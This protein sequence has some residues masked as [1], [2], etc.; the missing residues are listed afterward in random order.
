MAASNIFGRG[1]NN[2]K[3][4][5]ILEEIPD[6]LFSSKTIGQKITA[7]TDIKGMADKTAT[8]FVSKIEEFKLFLKECGLENK[9]QL[10]KSETEE[11]NVLSPLYKKTVF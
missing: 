4:E 10:T 6:I 7:V 11:V 1:F 8:T 9:L 5:L 2:K 3:M